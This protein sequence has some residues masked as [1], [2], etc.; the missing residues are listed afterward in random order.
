MHRYFIL[1]AGA[2]ALAVVTAPTRTFARDDESIR[3]GEK[4]SAQHGVQGT[5]DAGMAKMPTTA[6]AFAQHA[7]Q[8]GLAE[9]ALGKLAAT[10]A[11]DTDV[12]E[13]AQKMVD[14]HSKANAELASLAK[15]KSIP[16]PTDTDAKHKA[17]AD[18]L[19]KLSGAAFDKAFMHAMVGDHDHAVALFHTYSERGDDPE[20]KAWAT[21]TL[22]TLQEHE[23]LAKV[24]ATKVGVTARG[25]A[26]ADKHAA[27]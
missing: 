4:P 11:S 16:V 18:R 13:F 22:P 1:T 10:K 20:L 17:E 12:R 21:K 7:G 26:A 27:R 15:S 24:T 9:V 8:A 19:S 2:V 25:Q 23:R 3:Q 6:A 14:D 5:Q